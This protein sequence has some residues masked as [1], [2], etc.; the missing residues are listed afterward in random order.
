MKQLYQDRRSGEI[1]L[2]EV[3]GPQVRPGHLV[4]R[5]E[6]SAVSVGTERRSVRFAQRTL[7][8]KALERPDLVSRVIEKARLEGIAVAL[9]EAKGRLETPVA[10]GYSSAG[11]VEEVGEGV[12]EFEEGVRVACSGL[13]FAGHAERVVVPTHLAAPLPEG[14]AMKEGAFAAIG[15]I[16]LHACRL[17]EV[18]KGHSVLVVGLGLLGQLAVQI[19]N[20]WGCQVVALDPNPTR[21]RMANIHGADRAVVGGS[22]L[23][24]AEELQTL[25]GGGC[26]AVIIMASTNSNVPIE[27]AARAS[28]DGGRVVATGLVGL[29]VPR[30]YFFDR[31]LELVV[32]RGWGLGS[33]EPERARKTD[34]RPTAKANLE[35]FLDLLASGKLSLARV[36][37]HRFPFADAPKAYDLLLDNEEEHLGIVLT[38]KDSQPRTE[39]V[40]LRPGKT[41]AP[42]RLGVGVIGAGRH[43][44]ETILP[45]VAKNGTTEFVGLATRTPAEARHTATKFGFNYAATAVAEVLED[46]D[47]D[48]VFVLT[49]H[50][51]HAEIASRALYADKHVFLEKPLAL[52]RT[53]LDD[54]EQATRDKSD[55]V[56]MVGFNRRFAP[57]TRFL[58]DEFGP[59]PGPLSVHCTVNPGPVPETSWV[60]DPEVGG[61]LIVGEACHFVDL[62]QALTGERIEAVYA[63]SAAADRDNASVALRFADGSAATILYST[64]GTK[65]H[66]RERVEVVGGGAVGVIDN[67]RKATFRRG[68]KRRTEHSWLA[69]DRGHSAAINAFIRAIRTGYPPV[70]F[71]TYR[72]TT[73]ATFAALDSARSG[74][75]V[76]LD[77]AE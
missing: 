7:L 23:S 11:T 15:G 6:A 12:D 2:T 33:V 66:P 46:D 65:S 49:R 72:Q 26:Q 58:T 34:G 14:V 10:L 70:S 5:T 44:R 64:R 59:D 55:R 75:A 73:L 32:S 38:Y 41:R 39:N 9:R 16:S 30:S 43:A 13:G 53:G 48:L 76:R 21:V 54:L 19:L 77:K 29:E 71:D 37:T 63:T 4:V 27:L 51:S 18:R 24:L 17:A 69:S 31:E 28:A 22:D 45:L 60:R 8:G 68:S 52:D 56:F 74:K 3:P 47:V 62:T 40:S 36:I 57:M 42:E 1:H 61:G 25:T 20:A 35:G 50:N 67:F